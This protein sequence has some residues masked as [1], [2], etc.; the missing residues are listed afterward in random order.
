MIATAAEAN[1]TCFS[2]TPITDLSRNLVPSYLRLVSALCQIAELSQPHGPSQT[3]YLG[4]HF[5]STKFCAAQFRGSHAEGSKAEQVNSHKIIACA[6][7]YDA[8]SS[9]VDNN[10]NGEEVFADIVR[11]IESRNGRI[12]PLSTTEP[13]VAVASAPPTPASDEG[14]LGTSSDA[15]NKPGIRPNPDEDP[16]TPSYSNSPD[17][18]VLLAPLL[19]ANDARKPVPAF[20][21]GRDVPTPTPLPSGASRTPNFAT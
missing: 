11:A 12:P 3:R 8:L 19:P 2:P 9:L 4:N 1:P 10:W 13:P 15:K 6:K 18:S 20:V 14:I 7:D 5:S 16:K 17:P 21:S